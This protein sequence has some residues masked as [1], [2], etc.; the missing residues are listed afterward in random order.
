MFVVTKGIYLDAGNVSPTF[1]WFFEE[2]ESKSK[3]VPVL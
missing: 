1:F 3:V 2:P